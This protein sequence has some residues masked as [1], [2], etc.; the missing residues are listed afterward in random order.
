MGAKIYAPGVAWSAAPGAG[1]SSSE[2]RHL[3]LPQA[4]HHPL[5]VTGRR[6]KIRV[7]GPDGV[8]T[9]IGQN[10]KALVALARAGTAGV[11][12]FKVNSWAYRFGAYVHVLRHRHSLAI[13]MIREAHNEV[14][15][16]HGRYIRRSP[17]SRLEPTL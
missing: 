9:A 17:V 7:R 4:S 5:V 11:A 3:P 8:F 2:S 1:L 16:W 15:D 10:A 14:G 12:A 13:D 6:L